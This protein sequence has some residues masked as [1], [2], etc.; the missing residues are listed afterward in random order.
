MVLCNVKMVCDDV[1]EYFQKDDTN[2]P[3]L[4]V[5]ENLYPYYCGQ[6]KD[7]YLK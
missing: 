5:V 4:V 7:D 2:P 1:A 6:I 3:T